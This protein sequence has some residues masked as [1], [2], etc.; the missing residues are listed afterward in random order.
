MEK[1]LRYLMIVFA[2]LG[3]LSVNAQTH[4]YG[5]THSANHEQ[6]AYTG[7]HVNPQMPT[8]T[9]GYTHSEYMT[10]GSTLPQAAVEGT[11][12]TYDQGNNGPRKGGPRRATLGDDD[13][14]DD[15]PHDDEEPWSTPIGDA[16]I[17]LALLA[18]AYLIIRVVRRR[19]KGGRT[20]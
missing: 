10:S 6:A 16:A 12:T 20:A 8:A 1:T 14:E 5:A 4:Q 7:V 19:A 18:C 2:T 11:T 3:V 13:W 15:T 17:P 9:M